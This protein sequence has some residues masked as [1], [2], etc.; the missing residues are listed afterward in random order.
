M[1]VER[2]RLVT[3]DQDVSTEGQDLSL[4]ALA[5]SRGGPG[6]GPGTQSSLA[7]SKCLRVKALWPRPGAGTACG[8]TG[9][10][11]ET[12]GNLGTW[13]YSQA[14]LRW[15]GISHTGSTEGVSPINIF[16]FREI[17]SH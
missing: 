14:A 15:D 12:E 6:W 9:K 17:F 10:D 7:Q 11:V 8:E 13:T 16:G 4:G 3:Q 5:P 2:R 1:E